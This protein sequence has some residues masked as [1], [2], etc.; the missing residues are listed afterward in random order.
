VA[1][2]NEIFPSLGGTRP[3]VCSRHVRGSILRIFF[4]FFLSPCDLHVSCCLATSVVRSR[5]TGWP[6]ALIHFQEFRP[7]SLIHSQEFGLDSSFPSKNSESTHPS[8]SRGLLDSPIH[9]QQFRLDILIHFQEFS[10]DSLN[11]FQRRIQNIE[12]RNYSITYRR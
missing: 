9:F 12:Y 11:H 5:S 1:D 4:L 10:L 8:L 3:S 2:Q 6:S 7:K